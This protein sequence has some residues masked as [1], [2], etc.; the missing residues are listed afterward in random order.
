MRSNDGASLW[1]A[2]L[3]STR[4][5]PLFAAGRL[6]EIGA[7][8]RDAGVFRKEPAYFVVCCVMNGKTSRRA[9]RTRNVE[10]LRKRGVHVFTQGLSKKLR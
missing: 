4:L 2:L 7:D 9:S 6:H 8:L 3:G 5:L 10:C 1:S